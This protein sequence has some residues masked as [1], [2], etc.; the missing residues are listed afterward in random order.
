ARP[1][2][3]ALKSDASKAVKLFE[4]KLAPAVEIPP[5]RIAGWVAE[6]D[7]EDFDRRTAAQK[8]LADVGDQ[9]EPQ[10][11]QAVRKPT[12]VEQARRAEALLRRLDPKHD[13]NHQRHLRAL[14]ILEG[15]ATK[16]AVALLEKLA[17]GAPTARLT[18]EAKESLQRLKERDE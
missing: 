7:S 9:A 5:A 11:R 1:A 10:L 18:R 15:A 3:A 4:Q 16:E 13:A 12:S 14:E 2:I 8:R 17:K 6:L